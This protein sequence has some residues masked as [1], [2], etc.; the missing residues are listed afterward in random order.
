VPFQKKLHSARNLQDSADVAQAAN[1]DQVR[2]AIEEMLSLT[3][4]LGFRTYPQWA[5]TWE[6]T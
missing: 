6:R 2:Q 3:F 5:R 4:P 1:E